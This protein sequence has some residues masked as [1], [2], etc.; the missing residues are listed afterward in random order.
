MMKIKLHLLSAKKAKN[1]KLTF[2]WR[3]FREQNNRAAKHSSK[4]HAENSGFPPS[5]SMK[6]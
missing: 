3:L 6:R 2:V 1:L 4:Y 5:K